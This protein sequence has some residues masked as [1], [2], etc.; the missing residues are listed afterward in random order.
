[1]LVKPWLDDGDVRLYLGEARRVLAALPERS[2][3]TVVTSPPYW[4][5]RDYDSPDQIGLEPSPEFYTEAIVSVFAAVRRVLRDDGTVWLNLGDSYSG[6]GYSNHD[7]TGGAQRSDGGKQRHLLTSMTGLKAKDLCMIPARVALALQSDGWYL[8]SDVVWAKPNCMPESVTD[9]PTQAHEHV[10]LLS[11][12]STYFYDAEAVREAFETTTMPGSRI[13]TTEH[14]GAE[15]GGNTGLT[16]HLAEVKERLRDERRPQV[17][18]LDGMEPEAARGP[19][20]RRQ[21]HVEAREGSHQHRDGERWPHAGRNMRNVWTI[22][23][24]STPDAHFATFPRELARRC[25]AAGT[26]E[27]GAC[28]AC[29]SPWRRVIERTGHEATREAA[30]QPGNTE[31]K[32]DS[33]GWAPATRWTDQWEPSCGCA[34]GDGNTAEGYPPKLAACVVL[35]P[36]VGSGTTALVARKMG[37]HAIGIDLNEAY[38]GIAER[39]LGQLSLLADA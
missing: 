18:A 13:Q 22:A 6:A 36:F 1:M 2:V 39:R 9:R 11:K 34:S 23:T 15:N 24:E 29:G 27:H 4:G 31:T 3:Q 33:T 26:S 30:H 17:E 38:L 14:Y 35:D 8:R 16:G 37:R 21:T 10:F 12:R 5:L 19:D 32:T 28:P 7:G 25:I 20:G